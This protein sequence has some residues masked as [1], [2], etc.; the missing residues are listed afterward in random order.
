ML[1]HFILIHFHLFACFR[2]FNLTRSKK[3]KCN[4]FSLSVLSFFVSGFAFACLSLY[5][6][7][8]ELFTGSMDWIGL[9]LRHGPI[10][11]SSL[12]YSH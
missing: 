2:I 5:S 8:E 12:F 9:T 4:R 11:I 7:P 6:G 1:N 10:F 3:I